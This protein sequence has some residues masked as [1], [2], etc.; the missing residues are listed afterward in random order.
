M[1]SQALLRAWQITASILAAI[2]AALLVLNLAYSFRVIV[3]GTEGFLGYDAVPTHFQGKSAHRVTGFDPE[4]PLPSAGVKTGDL[5]VDP[6][7]GT[8]MAGESVKLQIVHEGAASSVEVK[9]ARIDRLSTPVQSVLDFGL[10]ILVFVL[11]L[12]IAWRRRRDAGALVLACVSL[13]GV[14]G[15]VPNALPAGRL[16]GV[17]QAWQSI[18]IVLA[19][20][21]LAY[22]SV[23]F[24]GGYQSRA[25]VQ[26][27]RAIVSLGAA[28]GASALAMAPYY[29][30]RVWLPPDSLLRTARSTAE[31]LGVVL[32]I[33]AFTD[34]W[35]H[36][37]AER[38]ARLRWLYVALGFILVNF[39]M[40]SALGATA[41][42]SAAAVGVSAASDAIAATAMLILTYAIL[43]HRVIDVGFV[44]N[45]AVVFAAF[46]GFLLVSFG[47]VEWLVD[48]FVRFENRE[49]SVLLD[50]TIAL[51]LYLTFHRTRRWIERL[52]ERVFFRSWHLKQAALQRFLDTAPHFSHPDALADALLA[53]ADAYAGSC[54]SGFYRQDD[55]GRFILKRSTLDRLPREVDADGEAIVEMKAFR[56]PVYLDKGSTLAPAVLAMPM[57][58]RSELVGFLTV[59]EKINRE[60]YR[61]DEIDILSRAV[62][63][64]G[65]D[66]Y[67][68]QFEQLEQ[69]RRELEQQNEGLREAFRS[70]LKPH[71]VNPAASGPRDTG[72]SG[73]QADRR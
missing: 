58:R 17:M 68:L 44:I 38:R 36:V 11:A 47:L 9:A 71:M 13:M 70:L 31:F 25:R 1:H 3:P 43:R 24:E 72:S 59:G 16:V 35:R 66:L 55:M 69:R 64:T 42:T 56:R 39:S 53:A 23:I 61:L 10:V 21:L 12:T 63:Q 2:S 32:C 40:F 7:R 4:S 8:F 51:A 48:H 57:L 20:P 54:G 30:G 33:V 26:I 15:L 5:I 34:T 46:T 45:R 19:L 6:P 65:V 22:F 18:C 67:A 73:P 50:G 27:L 60:I 49:R 14:A 52:V 28:A 37:D 62:Q 29:L 41:L